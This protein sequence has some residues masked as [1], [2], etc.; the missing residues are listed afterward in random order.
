MDADAD[1]ST[2]WV[3]WVIPFQRF[4]ERRCM[5]NAAIVVTVSEGIAQLIE[6]R[7]DRRPIIIR[8]VHD[9]RLDRELPHGLRDNLRLSADDFLLVCVGNA[10]HG[11]ALEATFA[12]LASM[13]S[14]VHL[15]FLGAGYEV[16]VEAV[17]MQGLQGRVHFVRSVKPNEVVPFIRTADAGI[18]LYYGKTAQYRF[19]LPN[20]FFQAIAAELPVLYPELPEIRRIGDQYG[21]G[22]L[23]DP[24]SQESICEAMD[25]L[26]N[27]PGRLSK[28]KEN[29]RTARL[30]LA[31]ESEERILRELL[32]DMIGPPDGDQP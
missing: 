19:A 8:N 16:H 26:M 23:I 17:R 30:A 2:F 31:Y 12:A 29:V 9:V 11:M 5:R 1:M 10:K 20:G 18:V 7:Y 24:H 25:T 32:L 13:P 15:A 4:V 14:R 6:A 3:R 28:L 21:L 22:L 27:E